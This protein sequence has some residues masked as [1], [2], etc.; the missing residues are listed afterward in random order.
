MSEYSNRPDKLVGTHT[1]NWFSLRTC[2]IRL[3]SSVHNKMLHNPSQT[4]VE[5][6]MGALGCPKGTPGPRFILVEIPKLT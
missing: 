2:H 1:F 6:L 5:N 4:S 3:M